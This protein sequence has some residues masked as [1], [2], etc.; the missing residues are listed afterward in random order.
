LINRRFSDIASRLPR[1]AFSPPANVRF[2]GSGSSAVL[3]ELQPLGDVMRLDVTARN[4]DSL[5]RQRDSLSE[6]SI[7]EKIYSDPN[8][9]GLTIQD[10]LS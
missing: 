6:D 10:I 5:P 4:L 1:R 3:S 7:G 2:R 8:I 9:G